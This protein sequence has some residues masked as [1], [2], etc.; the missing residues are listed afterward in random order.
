MSMV[1]LHFSL[2]T[3]VETL[4]SDDQSKLECVPV[5]VHI[6]AGIYQNVLQTPQ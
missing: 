5:Q 3:G 4:S 2:I 1:N 6:Y